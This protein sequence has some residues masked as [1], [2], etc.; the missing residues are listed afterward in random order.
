MDRRIRQVAAMLTA[1]LLAVAGMAG[2]VQGV[3]AD[4]Y[5]NHEPVNPRNPEERARNPFHLFQECIWERG[6]I[7]SADG[8][9]LARSVPAE[10]GRRCRF[11]RIYP[12]GDLAPHVVG[13]WSL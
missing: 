10:P 5:A 9:E 7:V 8:Q 4:F 11:T 2:W 6:L 1:L 12:S 3:R 13:Q